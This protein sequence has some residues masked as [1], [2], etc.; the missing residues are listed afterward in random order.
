M[1][2]NP[3][4][5]RTPAI[6]DNPKLRKPQREAYAALEAFARGP[7]KKKREVGIVLPVG[8]GKSGCIT[9]APFA[10]RSKRT[11]V[12]APNVKIAKQL[13]DDFDPACRNMFYIKCQVLDGQPYPEP[14]E[15]RG[16][17]TNK[18][19]LE[20]ADVVTTNIQQLQGKDNRWLQN[21][22]DT[23]FDLILFDEGHHNIAQTWTTLK[24]KF[25]AARIVNFSA[26]PL[27]ADGQLMA[28]DILYSYP[29]FQAIQEGYVKRLKAIVLNPRTLRYV[30]RQDG[31][32]IEVDLE[33]VRRLGEEDANFRRSIVT[34][35]ETLN[36]IVDASIR[37]LHRL[38]EAAG[39]QK[40]KIIAS[41]L[42][43]EHCRQIVQ[44][45]NERGQCA[46][47]VH[48]K[49]DSP[50][51]ERVLKRLENHELD[52]IVQVRKLGEGFDHPFLAVAAVFNLF[53]N[54]SPF[55]QFV[56]RIMRVIK[57]A[58]PGDVLNS[59]SVVFHAGANVAKRW[60]DFQKYSEADRDYF[61][62][63]LPTENLDFSS[64]DE[65]KR[66]PVSRD[67]EKGESC[68]VR[69]QDGVHLEEIPLIEED[70]EALDA[71]R[72]L[73]KKGYAPDQVYQAYNNLLEPVPTT[74]VRERQA[75]R[76]SLDMRVKNETKQILVDRGLNIEGRELDRQ[77]L[78]HSNFVVLKSAIDR[79]VNAAVGRQSGE[80][81]EFTRQ[82][83]EKIKRDFPQIA[84]RA[85]K[86]VFDA[87]N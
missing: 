1:E 3:F 73:Q 63:L 45:Y 52:V 26:T 23:F 62:Q 47:Y 87:K 24:E 68:D 66:E 12:V 34:S 27:R 32:E 64:S 13:R 37:E 11:L 71:L 70:A 7:D 18:A 83:L 31:Q 67:L 55:V 79:Q 48:S 15:I 28:G 17:T 16:K 85:I 54:L 40:L 56:G 6:Q 10:F 21:L 41:A 61:D 58:A 22:A 60:T 69:S 53:A 84:E 78:E 20:G 46:D 81:H 14:G 5:T 25:S 77:H 2:N 65:L 19:D 72:L 50:V 82:E 43:Y 80:R 8:C 59:G 76:G 86:G 4:Q 49:E 75:M 38:R 57:Q 29:V 42:N 51:N 44:A 35:T 33:E 30:R 74:R 9:L 39:N 36:T